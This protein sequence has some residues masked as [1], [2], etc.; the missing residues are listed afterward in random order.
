MT[1]WILASFSFSQKQLKCSPL[2]SPLFLRIY[3]ILPPASYH[4]SV[5]PS[6]L[7]CNSFPL[8]WKYCIIHHVSLIRLRYPQTPPPP[9][10]PITL[11]F[12]IHLW[13]CPDST[14]TSVGVF[15]FLQDL[16]KQR[17]NSRMSY[18]C[19]LV[20]LMF[21]HKS[22]L[23]E[24]LVFVFWRSLWCAGWELFLVQSCFLH[25]SQRSADDWLATC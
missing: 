4:L 15:C 24:A 10:T 2:I 20:F 3:S 21:Q 16:Y 17:S 7:R 14:K 5:T 12:T 1:N 13:Y 11:P 25:T 19:L 22:T 23:T 6:N 8:A 9:F 18:H